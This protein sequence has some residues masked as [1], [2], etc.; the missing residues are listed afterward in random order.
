MIKVDNGKV[1]TVGTKDEI[2]FDLM[3]I[4]DALLKNDDM[5]LDKKDLSG[6][7]NYVVEV[8]K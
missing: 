5:Q 4:C 7:V 1:E 3:H 2:I 6:I 8:N